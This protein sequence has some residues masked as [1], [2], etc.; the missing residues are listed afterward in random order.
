MIFLIGEEKRWNL[1]LFFLFF[2]SLSSVSAIAI[3]DDLHVNVQVTNASG[4]ID[5]GTYIFAFNI[6]TD[7]ACSN[8]VYSNITTMQTDSR[9]I[10]SY[11]LGN[12]GLNFTDQYWLCYYRNGTLI[13]NSKMGRVPYAFMAKNVTSSGII[14]DSNLN[15]S[16]YNISTTTGWFKG[17][18][19]WLIGS[20]STNYLTFNGTQLDFSESALNNTIDTRIGAGSGGAV[21]GLGTYGYVPMW[22]ATNRLNNSV[23]YQNGTNVGIGTISPSTLLDVNGTIN[24]S[25]ITINGTPVIAN[26]ITW[27]HA[28]NG[29]LATWSQ[30]M[31]GTVVADRTT[32]AMIIN[33]TLFKTTDWEANYTANNAAWLNT[34]NDT[35]YLKSNPYGYYNSTT[36][37]AELDP[38][39]TA[40]KTNVA[41]INQANAFGAYNQTFDTSTLFVDSVS[42]RVGV[43]TTSPGMKLEVIGG[44]GM[45]ATS[46]STQTSGIRV[47]GSGSNVLD[48]GVSNTNGKAWIQSTF[49]SD[50]SSNWPLLLNPNGGNVGIGTTAPQQ[51]LHVAGSVVINGTLN[52]DSNKI[53]SVANGTSAQDVVTYSQLQTVNTSATAAEVDPYW[54]GNQTNY[55][56]K[57]EVTTNISSANTSMKGYVDAQ[58]IAFNNSVAYYANTT[59]NNSMKSYVDMANV[60]MGYYTNTTFNGTL[61]NYFYL[62]SNPYGYYNSTYPQAELDPYW[63]ANKTNVAF[64]NQANAFGAYNQTF[65]TSTLFVDSVS[66]R[67]GVGTTNP[68]RLLSLGAPTSGLNIFTNRNTYIDSADDTANANIFVTGA[69]A[70]DFNSEAGHLVIQP[71]VQGTVYRDIYFAS[72]IANADAIMTIQG[73]GNV[74]IGT[75]S[76]QNTLNVVGSANVTGNMTIGSAT[77][78]M[79]GGNLVF[80]V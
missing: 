67:V 75:T 66:D 29:T 72:G 50:L 74:G 51:K 27:A 65:D 18:F 43:G 69:G 35:Y 14:F 2:L 70:G 10:I 6:T 21:S 7:E 24:A 28:V 45:P 13:N 33:G 5:N 47:T 34:T 15:T 26:G 1:I 68:G 39:W 58:D 22:N 80:R 31:N 76:P 53:T 32:W 20:T 8:V 17:L 41:F 12:V 54:T 23:I 59:V 19:N 42:D 61:A 38:Y 64:I 79:S 71:R 44:D 62:K 30:V 60:S 40:N 36:P 49:R 3:S 37:Q 77:A 25:Q 4:R 56:T 9:G 63:T 46:G 73:E 52:M 55:Y 16:T 48:F 78:F 57:S 11:Y